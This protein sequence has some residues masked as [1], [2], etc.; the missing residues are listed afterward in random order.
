MNS[1]HAALRLAAKSLKSCVFGRHVCCLEMLVLIDE[2]IRNSQQAL[3]SC[4]QKV[5]PPW[6]LLTCNSCTTEALLHCKESPLKPCPHLL[7][8]IANCVFLQVT[9]LQQALSNKEQAVR[10][11]EQAQEATR[12]EHQQ[13]QQQL[14]DLTGSQQKLKEQLGDALQSR[15]SS[16][17]AV[18]DLTNKV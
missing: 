13:L 7:S 3:T 10:Q 12:Q 17:E 1:A 5:M 8:I 16:Q 18:Q 2:R 11:A 15:E 14:Q 4:R 6:R 9:K